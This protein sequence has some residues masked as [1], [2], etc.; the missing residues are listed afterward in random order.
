MKKSVAA[1]S[2]SA[3]GLGL[4]AL[5][6]SPAVADDVVI[7]CTDMTEHVPASAPIPDNWFMECVPQ[8]GV[9]KAEFTVTSTYT[10]PGDFLPLDDPGV[11]STY[12]GD[13][14]A[15]AAYVGVSGLPA[16]FSSF[17]EVGPLQFEGNPI[18]PITGVSA[19]LPEDLP[20]GCDPLNLAYGNAYRVDYAPVVITFTQSAGGYDWSVTLN[21]AA[22]S[23][24][25]GLSFNASGSA[26]LDPSAPQCLSDGS[27]TVLAPG[28][29]ST[30]VLPV[31]LWI[32]NGAGEGL[33][34]MVFG[35][36]DLQNLGAFPLVRSGGATAPGLADTGAEASSTVV[37][38]G[39]VALLAGA[40]LLIVSRGRRRRDSA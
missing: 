14:A 34:P 22:P 40:A 36:T 29:S 26:I 25:L 1:A 19:I 2:A 8:F 3:M 7:P 37:G 4:V 28:G 39:A 18:F 30:A 13:A 31:L 11:T 15:A 21:F 27:E 20:S 17:T 10:L 5:G 23:M 9:G 35:T 12:S 32:D 16:G 38:L 6:G 33:P 24:F